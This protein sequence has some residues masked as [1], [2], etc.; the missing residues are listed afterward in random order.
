MSN[1]D[2][3]QAESVHV[4][5]LQGRVGR[6]AARLI[7]HAERFGLTPRQMSQ[8]K[9]PWYEIREPAP[10][11]P[12]E[13]RDGPSTAT[14]FIYEEIGGSMGVSAKKFAAD[15]A[16]LDVE[17]IKVR[18]NSPGGSVFDSIAIY[19]ALNHHP[20]RIMVYVDS[21][22]ASGASVIAMAGDE[23]VMMPGSQMMIHD[24]SMVQE[25]QASDMG[26][27]QVF[28]DRQSA[29]VAEI[30][31]AARGGEPTAWRELMLAETW[32]FAREAVQMGLAD[33]V[34]AVERPQQDVGEGVETRTFNME[35]FGYRYASREQA[36]APGSVT[37]TA[38]PARAAVH[39]RERSAAPQTPPQAV[40]PP[41]RD[42][43]DAAARRR[44]LFEAGAGTQVPL[45][46]ARRLSTAWIGGQG[47]GIAI[48]TITLPTRLRVREET[49]DGKPFFVVEG[50]AT[51]FEVGYDMWDWAGPYTEIVSTGSADNTLSRSPDTVFL[52][53]HMGLALAR[54]AIANT[55]DLGAD[56]T[57]MWDRAW[58]NPQRTEVQNLVT[59][60]NDKITTE[61]SFAFMIDDGAWSEDFTTFR[62][63]AFDIHRGDVSA[64][65]FGANP[66][67]S[68]GARSREVLDE[69]AQLPL[70]VA[71]EALDRLNRRADLSVPRQ[72]RTGHGVAVA[73]QH[74]ADPDTEIRSGRTLSSVEAWLAMSEALS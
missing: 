23:I 74:P 14:V 50:Y 61:Q 70:G 51:V 18:I 13:S 39:T 5:R 45:G 12:G 38:R 15:L 44:E 34:L 71:R 42:I 60:I 66:Y 72:T 2:D 69:I 28:L 20:A 43:R 57:G 31:A 56:G 30:Y 36:P 32:A 67:T 11:A 8:V 1:I 33:S 41:T 21:L 52:I 37:R 17:Q 62:I 47:A 7:E 54:T 10:L 58:L 27:A 25:G 63:N 46:A 22:A 64:V 3:Q 73:A 65:N 24:A 35:S 55:L 9:L 48:P 59:N 29:N 19:N 53:N 6:T 40:L 68:I 26:A 4:R 49:R 16:A